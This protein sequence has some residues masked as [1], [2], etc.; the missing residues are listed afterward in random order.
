M[1]GL[2]GKQILAADSEVPVVRISDNAK[3]AEVDINVLNPTANDATVSIAISKQNA[4]PQADDYI[5][6]GLILT[7]GGSVLIRAKEILDPTERVYVKSNVDGVVVRV[8]G[9]EHV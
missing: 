2:L 6:K 8:T 1:K 3:Y 4:T 7:N 9:I 5:E